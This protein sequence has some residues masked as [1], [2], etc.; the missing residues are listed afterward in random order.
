MNFVI[1]VIL[2]GIRVWLFLIFFF[3]KELKYIYILT[4]RKFISFESTLFF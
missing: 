4:K 1:N 2:I 3:I